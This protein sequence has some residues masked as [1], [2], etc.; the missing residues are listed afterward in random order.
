MN[1]EIPILYSTSM[2]Q[3]KLAWRKTQT[4]RLAKNHPGNQYPDDECWHTTHCSFQTYYSEDHAG[5]GN[6]KELGPE[7]LILNEDGDID[8]FLG[9]CPYGKPGDLLWGRESMCFV[10]RD[11]AHDLLE[12]MKSQFVYKASV[13]PDW[14][15]YAKERHAYKWTPSIHMPKAAARIWE[16]L[17][18]LRKELQQVMQDMDSMEE[19]F[20]RNQIKTDTYEKFHNRYSSQIASLNHQIR[21]HSTGADQQWQQFRDGLNRLENVEWL[22][23]NASLMQKHEFIRLLFNSSLYYDG[24]IYRT[25]YIMELFH[26][27]LLTLK[28]K[29][30]LQID[31]AGFAMVKSMECT[32]SQTSIELS[33]QFFT[34]INN[35]K[36]A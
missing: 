2:V 6:E 12:G 3:A 25:A 32:P 18:R 21:Q 31:E 9:K 5:D 24:Q 26:H 28:E 34:L 16:E 7:W 17:V 35:I 29:N 11:H 14:M 33:A 23:Q 36:T 15:E 27:N 8:G 30:L 13:H 20:I 22:W 10:L 1:K 19:K 4:R